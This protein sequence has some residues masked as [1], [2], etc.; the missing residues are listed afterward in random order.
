MPPPVPSPLAPRPRPALPV[1]PPPPSRLLPPITA[2]SPS[3]KRLPAPAALPSAS[4]AL[5]PRF[6]PALAEPL[7]SDNDGGGAGSI[8]FSLISVLEFP[9][10]GTGLVSS[11]GLERSFGAMISFGFGAGGATSIFLGSSTRGT[12]TSSMGTMAGLIGLACI[13][14]AASGMIPK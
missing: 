8:G 5:D 6:Q 9:S 2:V 4:L 14:N 13:T 7:L 12:S 1:P 3:P 11:V 10:G